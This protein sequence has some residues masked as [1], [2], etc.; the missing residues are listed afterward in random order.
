MSS[1]IRITISGGGLA[2]ECFLR[3]L[4]PYAHLGVHIFES[5]AAFKE[6]GMAVGVARNALAALDLMGRPAAQ[7]LERAGAVPV[8][9][10]RF[11]LAQ[12]EGKGNMIDETKDEALGQR[13]T[14]IVHSAAFLQELLADAPPERMYAAKKLE[15]IDRNSDGSIT[16]HFADGTSHDCDILIG[17]DGIRSTI[18]KLV[19][20]EDDP[21]ASPRNTGSWA[22]MALK[23]YAEAQA[24]IGEGPVNKKD[25]REYMWT[26]DNAY[27]MHNVLNEGQLVQVIIASYEKKTE[28]SHAGIEL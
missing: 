15:D 27:L 17:A 3:A 11:M 18:R 14:S 12:G 10:V 26:G 8:L 5:A 9:G 13:V 2:G 22:V 25:A 21:V 28:S 6:A 23:P 7:C 20:G 4:A 1:P 16:L 19:L 24:S